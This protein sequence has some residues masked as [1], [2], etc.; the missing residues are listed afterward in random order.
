MDRNISQFYPSNVLS[1]KIVY[2]DFLQTSNSL[3]IYCVFQGVIPTAENDLSQN[4]VLVFTSCGKG[5][6]L[7]D[8]AGYFTDITGVT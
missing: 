2:H 6:Y 3:K 5:L 8:L 4:L 7:N 1:N